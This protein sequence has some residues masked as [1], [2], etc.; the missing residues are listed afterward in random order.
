MYYT[1]PCFNVNALT[2]EELS[3]CTLENNY[4]LTNF[5]RMTLKN[6]PSVQ[7]EGDRSE[8]K[9]ILRR[10]DLSSVSARLYVLVIC[11]WIL[12]IYSLRLIKREWVWML[13]MRRVYYLEED[14]WEKRRDELES[15][16]TNDDC[17]E[18][19]DETYDFQNRRKINNMRKNM[20]QQDSGLKKGNFKTKRDPWIPH[21]EQRETIPSVELYSVLIGGLPS[22]PKEF[23]DEDDVEAVRHAQKESIDWQLSLASTV[24]DH[25]IPNQPGFSSSVAAVT[26]LP[27]ARELASAWRQWYKAAAALRR[28]TF[29][30]KIMKEKKYYDIEEDDPTERQNNQN[31]AHED[32]FEQEQLDYINAELKDVDVYKN[33]DKLQSFYRRIFGNTDHEDIEN[34]LFN[35]F[36]FGP[37]QSAVYSREFAQGAAACCPNGCCEERLYRKSYDELECLEHECKRR[38]ESTYLDLQRAQSKAILS[39]KTKSASD[40]NPR[41]GSMEKKNVTKQIPLKTVGT[42]NVDNKKTSK[43]HKRVPSIDLDKFPNKLETEANLL[44]KLT[45]SPGD[46]PLTSKPEYIQ[47]KGYRNHVP[48]TKTSILRSTG[49]L[50]AA[51]TSQKMGSSNKFNEVTETSRQLKIQTIQLNE[52]IPFVNDSYDSYDDSYPLPT[53]MIIDDKYGN[54]TQNNQIKTSNNNKNDLS[55]DFQKAPVIARNPQ[56]PIPTSPANSQ[57]HM[58]RFTTTNLNPSTNLNQSFSLT[59]TGKFRYNNLVSDDLSDIA[60]SNVVPSP[61]HMPNFAIKTSD[62]YNGDESLLD[63]VNKRIPGSPHVARPRINTDPSFCRRRLNTDSSFYSRPKSEQSEQRKKFESIINDHRY[64]TMRDTTPIGKHAGTWGNSFE[65][66]VASFRR[67]FLVLKSW[68]FRTTKKTVDELA[69]ESTFAVVTFTSRQSAVAARRCLADGRGDNRWAAVESLPIPP[70]ADAASMDFKTCRGCCR[71]VTMSLNQRQQFAR[72]AIATIL[73][74]IMFV[75]YSIPITLTAQLTTLE[76]LSDIWPDLKVFVEKYPRSQRFLSGIVPAL[77]FTLFFALCPVIFKAIANSGSN[78]VSVNRSEYSAL[79]YYWWFMLFTAFA[80]TAFGSMLFGVLETQQ[81]FET[82]SFQRVILEVAGTLPTTVAANWLNWI[83]IRT[84]VTLPLQYMLQVNTF[85]FQLLGWK[86]CRRCVMGGGPGG[87]IPYRIYID[88]GVVFLC[89]VTLSPSCPLI[90]PAALLYY[91]YCIPLWRR[92]CIFV[93]RPKFDT[94]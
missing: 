85:L 47:K 1:S 23:L 82:E 75:T 27:D 93:Y 20:A 87:H 45:K 48:L 94:G 36:D 3:N 46:A 30:R 33:V 35:A 92:N 70:L 17:E 26:I 4:N 42:P 37:E 62:E 66:F 39:N 71:P 80:G 24:F 59:A 52:G 14:H 49:D 25:C 50:S 72:K 68:C 41:D 57:R 8:N 18:E 38:L 64:S 13:A 5:E 51:A 19:I 10:I 76:K 2:A 43:G 79:K 29:I 6:I 9:S 56:H 12:T 32:Q 15:I 44:D 11:T 60:D 67:Y 89:V 16:I 77:L 83:I 90:A 31:Y 73:L 86:C 69:R 91:L 21:P 78:A 7:I 74:A 58:R 28:L 81:K 54:E 55:N 22:L 61:V 84:T 53:S 40:I 63:L 88:S 65:N 34:L